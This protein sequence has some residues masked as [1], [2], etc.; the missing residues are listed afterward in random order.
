[1]YKQLNEEL[2]DEY[3]RLLDK[4][5]ASQSGVYV[6]IDSLERASKNGINL[7]KSSNGKLYEDVRKNP[8]RKWLKEYISDPQNNAIKPEYFDKTSKVDLDSYG[9]LRRSL[10]DAL[11]MDHRVIEDY[12]NEIL[13]WKNY[14]KDTWSNTVDSNFDDLPD[15]DAFINEHMDKDVA[16]WLIINTYELDAINKDI[17]KAYTPF[18]ILTSYIDLEVL[19]EGTVSY[20]DKA[21]PDITMMAKGITEFQEHLKT[22]S[23]NAT[24][25]PKSIEKFIS[26][27]LK[28][29]S[30][31][32]KFKTLYKDIADLRKNI[33]SKYSMFT[34]VMG[35]IHKLDDF[36]DYYTQLSLPDSPIRQSLE[37]AI[38][39]LM[40]QTDEVSQ[41]TSAYLRELIAKVDAS[42]VLENTL[43]TIELPAILHTI[44]GGQAIEDA[45]N[46]AVKDLFYSTIY[47]FRRSRT[48]TMY[49]MT[50]SL[51]NKFMNNFDRNIKPALTKMLEQGEVK[52]IPEGETIDT[53]L[54]LAIQQF[55]S[56]V[57]MGFEDYSQAMLRI[58]YNTGLD[59]PYMYVL[60]NR[61]VNVAQQLKVDYADIMSTML[62]Y[63]TH[64]ESVHKL[65][66]NFAGGVSQEITDDVLNSFK[67]QADKIGDELHGALNLDINLDQKYMNSFKTAM[68]TAYNEIYTVNNELSKSLG[69]IGRT[70][71]FKGVAKKVTQDTVYLTVDTLNR[72]ALENIFVDNAYALSLF[73][74]TTAKKVN[75]KYVIDSI[76]SLDLLNPKISDNEY[77]L[78][79]ET[80]QTSK[81]KVKSY[82][83]LRDDMGEV[84]KK[85][86]TKFF[87]EPR[88]NWGPKDPET[89]FKHL[90]TEDLYIWNDM[91]RGKSLHKNN[92][93][94]V[95][96]CKDYTSALASSRL[97][98][99]VPFTYELDELQYNLDYATNPK[100]F[101]DS[102][103]GFS[104]S[105]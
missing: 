30:F 44:G 3:L 83:N 29:N 27:D 64:Q 100:L 49:D 65:V 7:F 41:R 5:K 59:L 84:Y 70:G 97:E 4:L 38:A 86:L 96:L 99:L 39:H 69:K 8:F 85:A 11:G 78:L 73:T 63:N 51:I 93:T 10:F 79:V 57:R 58:S 18:E 67:A 56:T 105:L 15:L 6:T 77:K 62:G 61:A 43:N 74:S 22:I 60:D 92:I 75:P 37:A 68:Y 36:S 72:W 55:K 40:Y 52:Y 45:I 19:T 14:G 34:T 17:R 35:Y 89:Y 76:I 104:E 101:I 98:R 2:A 48:S 87:S 21:L 24:D 9:S 28:P 103:N 47:E 80:Y 26:L 12:N 13:R 81:V 90:S 102:S 53:I 82:S 20:A 25:I 66:Q 32:T 50:Q 42:N 95:N 91:V 88:A 23:A 71:Y 16:D 1:M 33:Q 94:Y 31:S 46:V 54:S